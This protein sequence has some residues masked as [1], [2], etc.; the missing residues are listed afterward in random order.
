MKTVGFIGLGNMGRPMAANLCKGGM[1]VLVHDV[2]PDAARKF[3]D[4]WDGVVAVT[5]PSD[6]ANCQV[7]VTMLPTGADVADALLDSAGSIGSH[8][9]PGTVVVDMSSA[10]P[11]GTRALGERLA[12][13]GIQLVDAPVSGG[14][15]RAETGTLALMVG[16][17]SDAIEKVRPM[18]QLLG[19]RIFEVGSLGCGHAMKALNNFVAG[20]AFVAASEAVMV[21]QRFGLDPNVMMDV[22]NVSTGR[23]FNTEMVMKQHVISE[24]YASGFALGLLT[25]DVGIAASLATAIGVTAPLSQEITNRLTEARDSVGAAQDHT[26]AAQFWNSQ[27]SSPEKRQ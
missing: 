20:T 8:L 22:M 17:E 27:V 25:K 4:D 19:D 12:A 18:L 14:V 26:R 10:D 13:I 2:L 15:P 23:C 3:A 11:V 7:I 1:H 5:S 24:A 16:G 9:K 21:G 6:F